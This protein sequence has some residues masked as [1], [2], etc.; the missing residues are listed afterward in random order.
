MQIPLPS[1][2]S[3]LLYSTDVVLLFWCVYLPLLPPEGGLQ[4]L[5]GTASQLTKVLQDNSHSQLALMCT[6]QVAR[7]LELLGLGWRQFCLKS[8]YCL[9]LEWCIFSRHCGH[10]I[11]ILLSRGV[12]WLLWM[13]FFSRGKQS[14]WSSSTLFSIRS[15]VILYHLNHHDYL[16]P[17]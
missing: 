2:S 15:E 1:L 16:C 12:S 6:M 14:C 4:S 7:S 10:I 11:V 13:P 9:N 8:I 5:L 3:S 17:D